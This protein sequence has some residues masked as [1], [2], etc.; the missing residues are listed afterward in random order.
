MTARRLLVVLSALLLVSVPHSLFSQAVT[1]SI[2]GTVTDSTGAVVANAKVTTNRSNKL[3]SSLI[4][5]AM[6]EN[7]PDEV[8]D[9]ART[10]D[11]SPNNIRGTRVLLRLQ[12]QLQRL[13]AEHRD[14]D[15]EQLRRETLT[16]HH[17][18]EQ[19]V[20]LMDQE[21]DVD[22]YVSYLLKLHG[23]ITAWEEWAAPNAP[24][25]IQPLLAARRRG[26]LLMLD[27]T[28]F[29]ADA[30]GEARPA[31]PEMTDAAGLLGAMYVMEGS[32]LGGQLIA[33]HVEV[34]LGLAAG[35]GNAYFRGHNERTGQLWKEFCDAL[36]TKVP[37]SET[38]AVIV[39]AKAMFGVF[40]SWMRM[41]S[42]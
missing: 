37:E 19:C 17:A 14:M 34:A 22:T 8:L 15:L 11:R 27:L 29:G 21:L 16:D 6:I 9:Q 33:R 3:A 32:T 30:S 24:A 13:L 1:G 38:A 2:L 18:V 12:A 35:Q 10:L 28:W 4:W 39:A 41:A 25:W 26:Q 20:P 7:C 36:R 40:G 31:L 42:K 23:M 5:T